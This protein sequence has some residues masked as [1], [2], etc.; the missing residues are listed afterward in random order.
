MR[1][2]VL[3]W[4]AI[5]ESFQEVIERDHVVLWEEDKQTTTVV[6]EWR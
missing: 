2:D 5:S 4:H 3:D 1:V 6:N